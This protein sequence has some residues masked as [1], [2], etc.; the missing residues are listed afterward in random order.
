MKQQKVKCSVCNGTGELSPPN[1]TIKER[2]ARRAGIANKLRKE[3]YSI[4]E[5]AALMGYSSPNSVF[6]LLD[7]K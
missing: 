5:I 1:N 4:R 3:G 6:V 2:Q 7:K